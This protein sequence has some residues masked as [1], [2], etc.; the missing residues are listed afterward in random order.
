MA[1]LASQESQDLVGTVDSQESVDSLGIVVSQESLVLVD[2]QESVDSVDIA[3]YLGF[4]VTP[5]SLVS[6]ESPA[7]LVIPVSQVTPVPLVSPDIL[8]TTPVAVDTVV[9]RD[10]HERQEHLVT[11][12]FQGLVEPMEHLDLVDTVELPDSPASLASLVTQENL[13]TQELVDTLVTLV[14]QVRTDR[15]IQREE[16][17]KNKL[18]SNKISRMLLMI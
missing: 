14:S 12:E 3:E 8:E 1:T 4:Q 18:Q 2:S 16:L 6:Q 5:V 10:I 7:S 17:L 13:A 15:D 11:V 9:F